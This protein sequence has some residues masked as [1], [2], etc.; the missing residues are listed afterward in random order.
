M[1][2]AYLTG[3]LLSLLAISCGREFEAPPPA[4]T[5][6]DFSPDHGF[7]D[8]PVGICGNNFDPQPESNLVYFGKHA[9]NC[10]TQVGE[11][12]TCHD[13]LLPHCFDTM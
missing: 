8:T 2:R 6:S 9:F 11:G 4:A 5:I 12:S 3:V 1:G 7:M 10:H 13:E